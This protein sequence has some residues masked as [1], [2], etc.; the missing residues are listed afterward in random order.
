[1]CSI[2]KNTH[3]AELIQKTSL[4]VWD[5]APIN[6]RY[7]FEALDRTL[8]DVLSET[9]QNSDNLLFGG[10]TFVLGGDFRQ[11]LPVVQNATPRQILR[12]CIVNSY[13]WKE[14]TLLQLTKNMRL[15]LQL[16]KNMRLKLG[17]LSTSDR[18]ELSKFVEW[19]L[20]NLLFLSQINLAIHL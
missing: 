5:E 10:I 11:T 9:R 17:N 8:R 4:I 3:L 7:C 16:T 13:I 15:L 12:S 14:C 1:M 2:R 20:Q 6:H 18:E 19:L